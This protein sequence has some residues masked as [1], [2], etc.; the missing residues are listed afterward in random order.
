M[1]VQ[2]QLCRRGE[3]AGSCP[4]WGRW[5]CGLGM[6]EGHGGALVPESGGMGLDSALRGTMEDFLS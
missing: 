1:R 2:E 3:K 6:A 4:V 5:C